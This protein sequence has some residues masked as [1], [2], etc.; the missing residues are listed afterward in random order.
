MEDELAQ[1]RRPL[2]R[3]VLAAAPLP[4]EDLPRII[5]ERKKATSA[6]LRVGQADFLRGPINKLPS[7]RENLTDAP[8]GGVEV[9][10]DVCIRRA[11]QLAE[12]AFQVLRFEKSLPGVVLPKM[13]DVRLRRDLGLSVGTRGSGV[14]VN[15]TAG[16]IENARGLDWRTD[17][18]VVSKIKVDY[19]DLTTSGGQVRLIESWL[20]AEESLRAVT[21]TYALPF[22]R[23]E[24]ITLF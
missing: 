3:G 5:V 7:K 10:R 15:L 8:A 21:F 18:F 16:E 13:R 20:P 12:D 11:C 14:T 17:L 6:V 2:Q 23:E 24:K 9:T 1:R 19:P 22:I 4:V